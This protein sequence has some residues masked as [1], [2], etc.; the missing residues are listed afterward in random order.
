M[1]DES[2]KS[3]GPTSGDGTTCEPFRLAETGESISSAGDSPVRT[4]ALPDHA[5]DL[6]VSGL[7]FGRSSHASFAYYDPITFSLKTS[8]LSLFGDW[9]Q[10]SVTWPL[11]GTMQNGRCYRRARWMLHTCD[12]DCSFMPT[13]TA[14]MGRK[15]W[16]VNANQLG[17][18]RYPDHTIRNI[19]ELGAMPSVAQIEAAM[20]FPPGWTDLDVS[21]TPS[22]PK[23]PSGSDAE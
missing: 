10:F 19:V 20:G 4:S 16:S 22:S 7:V 5:P 6:R 9:P 15:G 13:P 18:G 17:K 14:S 11:S 1:Q 8:Q 12:K 2:S 23:S 21:A 3:T